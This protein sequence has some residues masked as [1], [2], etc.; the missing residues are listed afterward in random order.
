MRLQ[1]RPIQNYT[2]APMKE[3]QFGKPVP[4]PDDMEI[5]PIDSRYLT[6]FVTEIP[7]I[8]GADRFFPTAITTIL[9]QSVNQPI[10]R[11]S[12]LALSSWMADNQQGRPP[13]YTL[14]LL[15]R[16]LPGIQ[17]A[18]HDLS[19]TTTH[20]L[21]VSFLSWLSLMTGDLYTAHRHLKGM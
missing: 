15:Q 10:L 16:I 21:S 2:G 3:I 13:V 4:P 8:L 5:L 7:V 17:K 19:I 20:I 1:K 18:I 9:K 6:Y 11:H 12:I 14:R